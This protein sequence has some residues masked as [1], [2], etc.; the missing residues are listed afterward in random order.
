MV[1]CPLTLE[2]RESVCY[3]DGDISEWSVSD[4]VM[5]AEDMELS[6]KYDEKF[7]YFSGEKRRV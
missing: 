1:F 7:I 3:V 6:M 4:V 2:T 5:T